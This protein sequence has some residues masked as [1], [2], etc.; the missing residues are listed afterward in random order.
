MVMVAYGLGRKVPNLLCPIMG[1]AEK[2]RMSYG[3]VGAGSNSYEWFM[4]V[5]GLGR[6]VAHVLGCVWAGSKSCECVHGCVLAR[7]KS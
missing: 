6:I 5:H 1:S 3:C 4:V 2:L 7:P